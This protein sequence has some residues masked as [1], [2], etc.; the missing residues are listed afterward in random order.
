MKIAVPVQG[1]GNDTAVSTSFGRA[2]GFLVYDDDEGTTHI[3]NNSAAQSAGG[4]GIHA[5]QTIV[6]SGAK[7]LLTPQ[8]GGNAAKVLLAAGVKL[9][10]TR[11]G[12]TVM[13]NIDW[14]LKGELTELSEIHEGFHGH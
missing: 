12:L 8:C 10:K 5:A 2:A 13:E 1:P 4:A 7:T 11:Q 6:D 3:L 14:F 9:Y